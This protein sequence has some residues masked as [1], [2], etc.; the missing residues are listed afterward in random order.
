M[1]NSQCDTGA[2]P[3]TVQPLKKKKREFL[4]SS[5]QHRSYPDHWVPYN[6]AVVSQ[7]YAKAKEIRSWDIQIIMVAEFLCNSILTTFKRSKKPSFFFLMKISILIMYM[8]Y[9]FRLIRW[10]LLS[11]FYYIFLLVEKLRHFLLMQFFGWRRSKCSIVSLD[12]LKTYVMF[13]YLDR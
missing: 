8:K 3:S 1:R 12:L 2:K 11:C 7:E 13:L 9:M 6:W 4:K 5:Q 10:E